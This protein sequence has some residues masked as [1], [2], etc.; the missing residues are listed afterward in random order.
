MKTT[1]KYGKKADIALGMWVKL[2]RATSFFGKATL[3]DITSYGLTPPQ[4][5]VLESLGHLGPMKISGMCAK[6]LVSGGNLTVVI[7]NLERDGLVERKPSKEDRRA[8]TIQLTNK[9]QKLFKEIFTTHAKYVAK[10]ASV[11]T[12]QE[13]EQLAALAKKL[14]LGIQEK[15]IH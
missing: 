7:D 12:E 14:G 3:K 8:I 4:F 9:G 5:G 10:L 2:A 1:K 11:L 13:Q 6:Q 15:Y